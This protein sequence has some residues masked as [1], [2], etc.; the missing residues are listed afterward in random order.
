M[1]LQNRSLSCRNI[2]LYI[3]FQEPSQPD[4]ESGF[5]SESLQKS[6]QKGTTKEDRLTRSSEGDS[7][8][9]ENFSGKKTPPSKISAFVL[10]QDISRILDVYL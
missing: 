10:V 1:R 2:D 7:K 5:V 3:E 6:E 8:D 9:T 4:D